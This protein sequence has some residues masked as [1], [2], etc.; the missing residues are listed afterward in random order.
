M[1]LRILGVKE[2]EEVLVPALTFIAAVNPVCYMGAYPVFMDCDDNFCMDAD[3]LERFCR[4][5][6]RIE[7]GRLKN[8]SS[9]RTVSALIVVHVFGNLAD[10]ERITDIAA[11][12]QLKVLEDATEAI[13]SYYTAGRYS[14]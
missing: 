1:A 3:K 10:M 4:E 11:K 13:G 2:G 7:N 6:C 14:G 9:G 8:N 12:Y 5:E